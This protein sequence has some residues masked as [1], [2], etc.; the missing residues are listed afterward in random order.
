MRPIP[1]LIL[2]FESNIRQWPPTVSHFSR[3]VSDT[4]ESH[5]RDLIA[6]AMVAFKERCFTGA[7]RFLEE[8][9]DI[10]PGV[11]I[12]HYLLAKLAEADG[13]E[14]VADAEYRAARDQD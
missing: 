2:D 13:L 8:C 10:D 7:A 11:A 6:R 9:E 4:S 14:Q 12:T 3:P 5:Y 1:V